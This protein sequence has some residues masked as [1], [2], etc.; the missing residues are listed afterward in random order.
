MATIFETT[1]AVLLGA[2]VGETIRKG[3]IDVTMYNDIENGVTILML[4]NLSAM[5]GE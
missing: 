2:K 3:I 1:G 4:G 5:F